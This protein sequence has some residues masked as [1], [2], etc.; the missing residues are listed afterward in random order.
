MTPSSTVPLAH[1]PTATLVVICAEEE[2]AKR[3]EARLRNSGH[4][5]RTAWLNDLEEFED[6]LRRA[7]PDLVLCATNLPTLSAPDVV[8]LCGRY[9]PDLSTLF[10]APGPSTAAETAAALHVG[11]HDRVSALD[12]AHLAH[13]EE[14]C[15]RELRAHYLRRDLRLTR[16]RLADFESRHRKL[17]AGTADAVVHVQEG[18]ITHANSAFGAMLGYEAPDALQGNPLMDCVDGA[19]QAEV[20]AFLKLASQGKLPKE[21]KLEL[22]LRGRAGKVIKATAQATLGQSQGERLLELLIRAPTEAAPAAPEAP[23]GRSGLMTILSGAIQSNV[24]MH[25]ALTVVM[26]D[27]FAS[28]EQRL[29]YQ[30]SEEVLDQIGALIQQRLGPKEAMFRFSTALYALVISR[31]NPEEFSRL[32]ETLREDI[33]AQLFKTKSHETHVS[34]TVVCYPISGS[35][36]ADPVVDQAVGEVR[37]H[38]R[39]GGNRTAVIGKTAE[40]VKEAMEDQRRADQLKKALMENRMKLAY[41]SIASLEGDDRQHFDVLVR[42]MDESGHEVPAREFIPAAERHGVIVAVDRWVVGRALGVLSKRVGT[43]DQSSLFVRISEQTLREGD[44]FY[45]WFL[46]Q[47]RQRKIANHQLVIA[48]TESVVETHISKAK[49]LCTALRDAGAGIALDHF[50]TGTKSAQMLDVV[51]AAF[52]RF[53]YSFSRDFEDPALQSK[54]AALMDVAKKKDVK[55]IMGQVENAS[56][57]AR[58]WQLGVNYIQGFHIQ[59]PEAVLLSADVRR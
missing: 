8:R 23:A 29:G 13:L 22:E 43:K 16:A 19:G 17:L 59:A 35:D 41:Q 36:Q 58:L 52:V 55:T 11:A 45:K 38:S 53:D 5:V 34:A 49:A 47:T 25:R 7:P 57:M 30:E 6:L 51:P 56:A 18:I 50:G 12:T 46:E 42:M 10:L 44:S 24:G 21:P 28:I 3:I 20:K 48:V 14:A 40:S 32:A 33:A 37:K 26:V 27:A 9:A 54:L 2:V 39:E 4:P 15:L 1:A 31:P